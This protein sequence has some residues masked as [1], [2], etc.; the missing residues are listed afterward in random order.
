MRAI[1]KDSRASRRYR[2]ACLRDTT[3]SR[4]CGE[5]NTQGANRP[6]I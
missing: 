5:L 6:L 1:S 3:A 4:W 2:S